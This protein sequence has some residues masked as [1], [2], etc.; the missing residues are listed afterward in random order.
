MLQIIGY[1]TR[2]GNGHTSLV[3]NLDG[4]N[5]QQFYQKIIDC[6]QVYWIK[7]IGK[8][9][10]RIFLESMYIQ[11]E[12]I[13]IIELVNQTKEVK[14]YNVLVRVLYYSLYR[15]WI[16]FWIEIID[17]NSVC[18]FNWRSLVKRFS[19]TK[20]YPILIKLYLTYGR[21]KISRRRNKWSNG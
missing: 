12:L 10:V 8:I 17:I 13:I 20:R 11:G 1:K 5:H 3:R 16:Y 18:K 19:F 6:G 7:N 2:W 21:K 14:F 9:S 4:F 15:L